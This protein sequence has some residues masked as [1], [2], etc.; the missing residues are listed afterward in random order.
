MNLLSEQLLR[1]PGFHDTHQDIPEDKQLF[2]TSS[3]NISGM[4][5]SEN[6]I[7]LEGNFNGVLYTKKKVHITPSGIMKGVI[8]CSE[9]KVEGEFEGSV[10]SLKVNLCK[11][12]I[13][14]GAIHCN[15][16]NTEMNQYVDAT[17][18]L[19]SLET[20]VL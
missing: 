11:D 1:D 16:I 4:L 12:S 20:L 15:I 6:N 14:K 17:I 9:I 10:Y 5:D 13:L 2:I 7:T 19:L 3:T 8:I 18:N